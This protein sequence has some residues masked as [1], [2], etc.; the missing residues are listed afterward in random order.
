MYASIFLKIL[1]ESKEPARRGRI[2]SGTDADIAYP[3]KEKNGGTFRTYQGWLF[4]VC[5]GALT[6]QLGNFR[7]D[8]KNFQCSSDGKH[9]HKSKSKT[10]EISWTSDDLPLENLP[11]L[12]Y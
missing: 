10:V 5:W 12:F 11:G 9:P 7:R 6:G 3:F 2:L 8:P 4:G 1:S